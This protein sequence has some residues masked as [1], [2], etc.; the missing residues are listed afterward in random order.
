MNRHSSL[1]PPG[2]I[3]IR[4]LHHNPESSIA[5]DNQRNYV[6]GQNHEEE[7]NGCDGAGIAHLHPDGT[8]IQNVRHDRRGGIV[9]AGEARQRHRYGGDGEGG[10]DLH[11]SAEHQLR[12]HTGQD[13]APGDAAKPLATTFAA[14]N[15]CLLYTS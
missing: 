6:A 2:R 9:G 4:Q 12:P 3:L 15:A 10:G 11:N 1:F 8:R 5:L 7:Q 13:A 14:F